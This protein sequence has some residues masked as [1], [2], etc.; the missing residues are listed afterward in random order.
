MH[1]SR[2]LGIAHMSVPLLIWAGMVIAISMEAVVKFHAPTV[3]LE[4]GVDVGRQVFPA[5]MKAEWAWVLIAALAYFW[6]RQH[7]GH[8]GVVYFWFA[9][10]GCLLIQTLV[11]LPELMMQ[12]DWLIAGKPY[13]PNNV[14][15]WYVLVTKIKLI[16]LLAAAHFSLR[17][18]SS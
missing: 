14:H 1:F 6:K 13:P 17:S 8:S 2:S 15:I 7:Y 11:L 12:A 4:I 9:A 5:L 18:R 10:I 16:A 3:T